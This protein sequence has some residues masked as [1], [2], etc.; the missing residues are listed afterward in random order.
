MLL[1]AS[2]PHFIVRWH[3]IRP[4]VQPDTLFYKVAPT[5]HLKETAVCETWSG[6]LVPL[7]PRACHC[8]VRRCSSWC[9]GYYSGWPPSWFVGRCLPTGGNDT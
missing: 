3:E 2:L 1:S 8:R 7:A 9:E 4:V 5:R 6:S